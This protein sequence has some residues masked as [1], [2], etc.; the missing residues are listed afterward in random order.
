MNV[1]DPE[2]LLDDSPGRVVLLLGNEAI[3][4]GAVE[5]G[6]SVVAAYPGT[7]SSEIA[8]TLSLLASKGGFYMEYSTNEKVAMEVAASASF[9]G[10]RSLTCM[11]HVGLNV[12]SDAF[13]SL[14]HTGVRG[15]MVI[16]TVDD[17]F[18]WSSQNEQ[19]NRFF[20][21]FSGAPMLEP[22][23]PQEA[24]DIT[25]YAFELS[26][27]LQEP[28]L[29]RTTTRVSHARGDVKLGSTK[30]KP[31]LKGT[32]ER[33][34]RFGL[35]PASARVRHK[36]VLKRIEEARQLSEKS[37]L[38]SVFGDG[39]TGIITSGVSHNYVME[40]INALNLEASIFKL[41]FTHP[42]PEERLMSFMSSHDPIII[43]EELEPYLE[44]HVKALSNRLKKKVRIFGKQDGFFP[45]TGEFNTRIVIDG[46]SKSLDMKHVTVSPEIEKAYAEVQPLLP[47]RP[48]TLC[49]GCSHRATYYAVKVAAKGFNPLYSNDIG[50]YS[51][52]VAPPFQMY[53][54]MLCMGSGTGI[55][56]GFSAAQDQP[57]I[58]FAGDSTFFHASI[59]ALIN[60]VYNRHS[61]LLVVMDNGATAMTGHQ[62]HPGTG[63]SGMGKPA[64]KVKIEEIARG[65][66]VK[67][68][69][70]I[71]PFDV[72]K[73]IRVFRDTLK[74]VQER[75]EVAVV[76]SRRECALLT[77]RRKRKEKTPIMPWKVDP[78][79]CTGCMICV[80]EFACPAIFV[81]NEKVV[82]DPNI[83]VD[84]GVCAEICPYGAIE[85]EKDRHEVKTI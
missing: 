55:A 5:G 65:I 9:C 31:S 42:L 34:P 75:K 51:L 26:E 67:L 18:C 7:P 54:T 71:D 48:P 15:G 37:R 85:R 14:V 57:V 60:A 2:F 79:K 50:C 29:V 39:K 17:P 66:G 23:D 82:I 53:D 58:A 13:I 45:R 1:A 20:A 73:S 56:C 52:G 25:A 63:V 77:I 64:P 32:F 3:A 38:N 83:C 12:A 10:L 69:Y 16:I 19:D 84:C 81:A 78:E 22:S 49:A 43:V 11:K 36:V 30:R 62:P 70:V 76:V 8:D 41:G 61:F 59:P 40:A 72:K 74:K 33:D 24:K 80:E 28:V 21:Q 35:L 27:E 6:V 46:I 68:V 4:R 47:P 44:N